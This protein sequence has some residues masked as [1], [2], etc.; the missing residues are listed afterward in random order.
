MPMKLLTAEIIAAMPKERT[1]ANLPNEKIPVICKFF[2]ADGGWTW[3]I[4]EASLYTADGQEKAL[5]DTT[6][7]EREDPNND[8]LMF[9]Y[10]VSGLGSDCNELGTVS[11]N[12]LRSVKTRFNLGL[13]R[14]IHFP[15]GTRMMSEFVT[16]R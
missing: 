4:A 6:E 2:L 9:G 12:E 16:K 13:E 3:Y 7:A 10:I 1:T 11:F 14:D 15:V 5:R 8:I